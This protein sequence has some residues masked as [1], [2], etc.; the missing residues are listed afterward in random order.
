MGD[1]TET[2]QKRGFGRE[3]E[4]RGEGKNERDG[5]R[6]KDQTGQI[7]QE[8]PKKE[9]GAFFSQNTNVKRNDSNSFRKET[10]KPKFSIHEQPFV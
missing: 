5:D 1:E 10:T 7:R 3:R 4:R 9:I 2:G 8:T 6:D